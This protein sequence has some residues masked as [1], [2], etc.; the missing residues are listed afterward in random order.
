MT[1][2]IFGVKVIISYFFMTALLICIANDKSGIVIPLLFSICLHE[3]SHLVFLCLFGVKIREISLV[4]G[5]VGITH[6]QLDTKAQKIIC[7]LAGP[8]S[9]VLASAV[10]HLFSFDNL[11]MINLLLS[12]LNLFPARGLDGGS[13]IYALLEGH[14]SQDKI[15][16][17][18]RL[19]S[20]ILTLIIVCVF[21]LLLYANQAN[22]SLLLFALYLLIPLFMKIS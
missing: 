5:T 17:T 8:L 18:L 20:L 22:Y 2:K 1:I 10:F 9:N 16:I 7:L 4:P 19:F 6:T 21:F 3:L 11:F 14:L 15:N 13:I 12:I